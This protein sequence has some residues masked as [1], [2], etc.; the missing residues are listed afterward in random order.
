[1][2]RYLILF[3]TTHDAL[4]AEKKWPHSGHKGKLRPIPRSLSSSCGLCLETDLPPGVEPGSI[5]RQ[6][7]LH[8]EQVVEVRGRELVVLEKALSQ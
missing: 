1:M 3:P 8:W 4:L 6:Y 7:N 2:T 5:L